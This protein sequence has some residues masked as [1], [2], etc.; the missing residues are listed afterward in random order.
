MKFERRIAVFG[1]RNIDERLYQDTVKLGQLLAMEKW[2]VLCGGGGGVMEAIAMG[3]KA[4][5]G[6]CV[7]LLKGISMNEAN[8]YLSIPIMTNM[9][10]SR[11]ALL[12]YNCDAAVAVSGQYGTLSEIAYA[13]QLKKPVIG[14]KTWDIKGIIEVDTI[15]QVIKE[16][17]VYFNGK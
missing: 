6:T 9:G 14:Y 8:Q 5:Q 16:L 12:A 7:G 13:L 11:N 3:V 1:G 10:I 4:E 17:K 2:L 15:N